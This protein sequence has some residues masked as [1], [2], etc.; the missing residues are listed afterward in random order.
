MQV[1]GRTPIFDSRPDEFKGVSDITMRIAANWVDH[2][3]KD[4]LEKERGDIFEALAEQ[5]KWNLYI[6]KPKNMKAADIHGTLEKVAKDMYE[7]YV[8]KPFDEKVIRPSKAAHVR[9]SDAAHANI[10][11]EI[12]PAWLLENVTR[13]KL[14]QL[15]Q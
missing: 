6:I 4:I 1:I 5:W 3:A 15:F 13:Q 12:L 14:G 2:I 11:A 7:K 10:P 9:P 8:G